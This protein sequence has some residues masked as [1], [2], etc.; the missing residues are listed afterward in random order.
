[1]QKPEPAPAVVPK[2][3]PA[4]THT[5]Q[6]PGPEQAE[7]KPQTDTRHIAP[8]PGKK[9][10]AAAAEATKAEPP[11]KE[12]AKKG[13][14]KPAKRR[15]NAAAPGVYVIQ[16]GSFKDPAN[17]KKLSEALRKEGYDASIVTGQDAEG[18]TLHKVLAGKY[19]NKEDALAAMKKL[20]DSKRMDI[21][22][23]KL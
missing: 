21:I 2:P 18:A 20:K 22:L 11:K 15:D 5:A 16:M 7:S 6:T 12:T 9:Q 1:V 14:I 4:R 10:P 19:K 3:E 23:R 17:A 8:P 13:K